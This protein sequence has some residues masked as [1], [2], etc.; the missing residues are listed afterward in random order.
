VL[1][2]R[3]AADGRTVELHKCAVVELEPAQP[4]Y[5]M[6]IAMGRLLLGEAGGV[7]VFPLR[8][9]MKGGKEEGNVDGAGAA[10]KKRLHKKN[11]IVNGMVVPARHASHGGGGQGDTISTCKYS[12][13]LSSECVLWSFGLILNKRVENYS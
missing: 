3:L 12:T 4:V 10:G 2:P 5:A 8:G 9:L 7:R 11:G 13:P 1:G 6:E